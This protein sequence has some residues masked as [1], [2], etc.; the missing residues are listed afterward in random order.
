MWACTVMLVNQPHGYEEMA[1]FDVA[2][3][4]RNTMLF[5]PAVLS[6]IALPLL[7]SSANNKS[8]FNRILKI[9]VI[10]NFIISSIMAICISLIAAS[11]MKTYGDGF[12]EGKVVLII[13]TFSTILI[14][15]NSVFGQAI[16]GK[17]RMWVG[18]I[19]NLIWGIILLTLTHFFIKL[20]YGAKGLA[21]SLLISYSFH[22]ILATIFT[23][24]YLSRISSS[25]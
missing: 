4:W 1:I 10:I 7:S 25:T 24:K 22:T 14:S 11:I 21:Y 18:F 19:L 8:R 6:Q 17:G 16:A 12:V 23:T 13:M 15:I 3:Q 9:N 2:Y 20:G 5:I